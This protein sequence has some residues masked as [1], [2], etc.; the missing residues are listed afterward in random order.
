MAGHNPAAYQA[1]AEQPNAATGRRTVTPHH[2]RRVTAGYG[3]AQPAHGTGSVAVGCTPLRAGH[4]A[5]P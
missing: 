1:K 3:G 2:G 4:D 5:G